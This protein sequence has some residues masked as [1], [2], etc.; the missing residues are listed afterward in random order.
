MTKT[1][2]Y[3]DR[4]ILWRIMAGIGLH[5]EDR[6]LLQA[7]YSDVVAEL[8][9]DGHK[10]AQVEMP[11]GLR[12]GCSLSPLL[13]MVYVAGVVQRL[14]A[15]DCVFT[16]RHRESGQLVQR[17]IPALV[18]VD[19]FALL[20]GSPE[21]LQ[22]LLDLCGRKMTGLGLRFSAAKCVVLVGGGGGTRCVSRHNMEPT[23]Q[24]NPQ[25]HQHKIFG[26]PTDNELRLPLGI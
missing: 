26:H 15:L 1:Y 4:E 20:A 10:I 16:F 3:V 9:W 23:G 2:D 25:E 8:E 5:D 24:P 13:F 7:I 11:R 18:Y 6:V 17:R 12:H 22:K 19:D 14:A 21:E